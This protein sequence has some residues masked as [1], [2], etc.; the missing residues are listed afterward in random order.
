MMKKKS[1]TELQNF[2]FQNKRTNEADFEFTFSIS[3]LIFDIYMHQSYF[4]IKI[5]LIFLKK[6]NVYI[7]LSSFAELS[8]LQHNTNFGAVS[9]IITKVISQRVTNGLVSRENYRW[10]VQFFSRSFYS[11]YKFLK[12]FNH[13]NPY[14][15]LRNVLCIFFA[16]FE[17]SCGFRP[18]GFIFFTNVINVK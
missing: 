8:L 9:L 2:F 12:R 6:P 15:W 11:L 1:L 16:L 3:R 7:Q 5:T 13:L 17:L 10:V 18:Q 4:N 14:I